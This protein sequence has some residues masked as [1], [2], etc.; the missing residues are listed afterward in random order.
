MSGKNLG[1]AKHG[2]GH[3]IAERVTAIALAPLSIWAVYALIN[4][5]PLPY[6]GVVEWLRHP[7]N[8]ILSVLF[9]GFS[10]YHMGLGMQVVIEDYIHRRSTLM[11]LLLLNAFVWWAAGAAT[12]ISILKVAFSGVYA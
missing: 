12:I 3:F 11:G 10:F 8:T 4:L 2:A 6:E 5:S 7:L 9:T 1:S